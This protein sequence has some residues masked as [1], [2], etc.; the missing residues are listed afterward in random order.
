MISIIFQFTPPNSTGLLLL[1]NYKQKKISP[2]PKTIQLT[3][4]QNPN[5][6]SHTGSK[7]SKDKHKNKDNYKTKDKER[8][9]EKVIDKALEQNGADCVNEKNSENLVS[10]QKPIN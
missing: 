1:P 5:G 10:K 6:I 3:F 8:E 9:R 7:K 2:F 4:K